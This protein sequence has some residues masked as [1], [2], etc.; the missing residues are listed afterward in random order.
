MCANCVAQGALYVGGALGALRVMGARARA[1][2]SAGAPP[3][4]E[5]ATDLA[6]TAT[7]TTDTTTAGAVDGL[8]AG[9]PG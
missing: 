7:D 9:H 6:D 8:K 1:R 3:A 5:Q 4:A 2:R